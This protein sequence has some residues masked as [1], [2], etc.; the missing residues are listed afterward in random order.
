MP[1]QKT[2]DQK[3]I[4]TIKLQVDLIKDE[5]YRMQ[6]MADELRLQAQQT[7]MGVGIIAR[8]LDKY[9]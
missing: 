5:I 1:D 7:E 3:I 8:K 2:I 9:L 4:D 6:Q